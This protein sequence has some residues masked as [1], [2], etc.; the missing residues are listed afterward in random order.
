V[1]ALALK[2]HVALHLPEY[3]AG[4]TRMSSEL[5]SDDRF[6]SPP[7]FFKNIFQKKLFFK[8]KILRKYFSKK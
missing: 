5:C 4:F 8:N 6:P 3:D 7:F 1:G 2:L